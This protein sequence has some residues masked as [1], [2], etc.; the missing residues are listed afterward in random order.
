MMLSCC[1]RESDLFLSCAHQDYDRIKKL[2]ENGLVNVDAINEN[3]ETVLMH[4]CALGDQLMVQMLIDFKANIHKEDLNGWCPLMF[5][6]SNGHATV[7]EI[8]IQ[9]R[10]SSSQ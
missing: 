3:H 10:T 6:C 8:L 5:A 9:V 2:I 1:S 7:S 4:A